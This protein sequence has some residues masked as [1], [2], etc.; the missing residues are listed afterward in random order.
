MFNDR[1][2]VN[3]LERLTMEIYLM[4]VWQKYGDVLFDSRC[5]V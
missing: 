2:T 4:K 1:F 3:F 5:G